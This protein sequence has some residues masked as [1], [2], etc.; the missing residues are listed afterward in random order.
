MN[1]FKK[2]FSS[3]KTNEQEEVNVSAIY[4]N[5]YFDKR[6]KEE[7]IFDSIMFDGAKKMLKGFYIDNQMEQKIPN[8]I[9]HPVNLDQ[10]VNDGMGFLMYCKAMGVDNG[11]MVGTLAIAF[12]EFLVNTYGFKFY[13]DNEP[14]V[15]LRSMTLKY[16][17]EGAILSLYPFEYSVKV[18]NSESLFETLNEKIKTQLVN[19]PDVED[20]L[21]KF[22]SGGRIRKA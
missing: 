21:D 18:L 20:V 8:L 6:Y 3:K 17:K 9:N 14:E 11:V 15:P 16:D 10:V 2:L 12:S 19:L 1:F 22:L 13:K 7:N 5:E 4:T